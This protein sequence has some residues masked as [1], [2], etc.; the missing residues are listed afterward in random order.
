MVSKKVSESDGPLNHDTFFRK[1]KFQNFFFFLH[2]NL[3][4]FFRP[5]PIHAN[6]IV[7]FSRIE[8]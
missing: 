6:K 4:L 3:H 7:K 5:K 8:K 1:A 2:I